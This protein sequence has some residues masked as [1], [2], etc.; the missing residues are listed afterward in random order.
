MLSRFSTERIARFSARRP[1]LVVAAWAVLAVA[2]VWFAQGIG[3]VVTADA[4]L[5]GNVEFARADALIDERMPGSEHPTEQVVV[6]SDELTAIEPRFQAYV[7]Q[8]TEHL[9]GVESVLAVMSPFDAANAGLISADGH[10]A[11]IPV[12][13]DGS[14]GDAEDLAEPVMDIVDE[15]DGVSG[16]EVLVAGDGSIDA[17]FAETAEKDA[18]KS[19]VLGLPVALIV[20]VIV[21]GAAVAAGVPI[22]LALL[23]IVVAVGTTALLGRAFDLSMFVINMIIMIGLAVGI[24]YSLFIVERYREE[25]RRGRDKDEAIAVAGATASKAVLFSGLTVIVAVLGLMIVPSSIYRSL[26]AG[27]AIVAAFAVLG[28]LTLLPAVLS[29]LG[30]KVNALRLPW[31][32]EK[33]ADAEGGFW[34]AVASTV[35][36]HPVISVVSSVALLLAAAVPYATM[37]LGAAGVSTLPNNV[38]AFRAFRILDEEFKIS[39]LAP[40]EIVVDADD[41]NNPRVQAAIASLG[42]RLAADGDF[43][44]PEVRVSEAG[45]L[46]VI[47]TRISGDPQGNDAHAAVHRLRDE[48]IP[49]AFEGVDAE[50]LVT[51]PTAETVDMVALIADYTPIVFGFVLGLSF[52]LLLVVFRSI[53]VPVKAIIMNLLSVGAAYGLIVLVFQ[54]GIGNDIFGFEQVDRIEAWLP[55]FLFAVLFGLSM[56]YHVFLLSRIRERYD[57]TGDNTA[58]VAFGVRSTASIITGAALIM[59]AVFAAF[60]MGDLVSFQQMGF[61]LAVAVIIDA[62]VVRSVLVPASMVLLGNWNWYMPN[63]LAWLPEVSVE[64]HAEPVYVPA[65]QEVAFGGCD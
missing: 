48:H 40:A 8:L 37:E 43:G 7:E 19:E 24:D 18:Q 11:V 39:T 60:A 3:D 29:I 63:W 32:G 26:A 5:G 28:A 13:L 45:D 2:G 16:F 6:R 23:A 33:Q 53:V 27:A 42:E 49:A 41:V 20:L 47:S 12:V 51:G 58:A 17:A 30:D 31:R 21:F 50:V 64:G 54:H 36:R 44:P 65:A 46:A 38:E 22:A 57:Q 56:D 62:T 61:G 35:M 55:L 9:S 15:E 14:G 4:T 59:V 10:T 34:G 25:R 1:W 52:L